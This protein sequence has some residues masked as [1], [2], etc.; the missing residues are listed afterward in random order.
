M[1]IKPLSAGVIG[2]PIA[3]S[4]SPLIHRFWLAKLGIDGDYNR[5]PVRPDNLEA[6]VRGLPA[7]GLVGVNVTIPHKVAVMAYLDEVDAD[8]AA[9]GAVNTIVVSPG[10]RLVGYNTDST[11]FIDPLIGIDHPIRSAIVIGAG[12]AARAVL[13]ALRTMKMANVTVVNRNVSRSEDLI[14]D[15][16]EIQSIFPLSS[17]LSLDPT[18]LVINATSLG[19]TGQPPLLVRL[20]KL[21]DQ[22]VIYDLVYVPRETQLLLDA[23]V[24]GLRV[25]DGLEML[26]GQAAAAFYLF[27]GSKP[28]REHD[29]D[30]RALLIA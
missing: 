9:T 3:H 20:D 13:N 4:K 15:F 11:G 22:T 2:W 26:V 25:I 1:S 14:R 18:D 17:D 28:P 19:M 5:F 10:G 29:A 7:L 8:A 27:F 12:G 16:P 24:R 23:R 6:A 21:E 30:L